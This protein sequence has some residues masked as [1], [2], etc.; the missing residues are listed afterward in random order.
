MA[1]KK[2]NQLDTLTDEQVNDDD[3]LIPLAWD[4]TGV[5]H[6][7]SIAQL[8]ELFRVKRHIYTASGSEGDTLTI[9]ALED[10]NILAILRESAPIYEVESSPISS[11][12][13]WDGTDIVLGAVVGG[14]GERFLI[15]YNNE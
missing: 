2:I 12:Y 7:V 4:S 3:K 14:A 15:L 6:K 9:S 10:K 1:N 5:A 13:T 8:K 11:E